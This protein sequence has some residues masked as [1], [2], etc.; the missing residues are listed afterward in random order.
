MSGLATIQAGSDTERPRLV[1]TILPDKLTAV[2]A[3]QAITAALL[4][5]ERTG[6]GQHVRLSMLDAVIAF[7][8]ASDMGSQ[9]FVEDTPSRQESASALDLIYETATGAYTVASANRSAVAGVGSRAG[10]TRMVGRCTLPR[11]PASRQE[12]VNDRLVDDAGSFED[13][14]PRC[15][16][17]ELY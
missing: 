1:R 8:W 4:A 9:T 13:P 17:W 7:L 10:K 3:S 6:L 15:N 11:T 16:G 14:A 5:R 2:T 12:N